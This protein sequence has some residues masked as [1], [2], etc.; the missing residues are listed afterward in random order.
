[1]ISVYRK[2]VSVTNVKFLKLQRLLVLALLS[3]TAA[4]A[5]ADGE[6]IDQSKDATAD[7]L[8]NINVARGEVEIRG[9]NKTEVQV[10]GTLDEKTEAFIFTTTS[11]V[12]E[13]KVKVKDRNSS[14]YSEYGSDLTIYVPEASSIEF[15]GVSTDV[16][17]RGLV[18]SV[19]LQV[20][21]G[22]LYLNGG[23]S[24]ITAQTVSGDVEL[25]DSTG[26]VRVGTVSGEVET[27]N[28]TGDARY[29]TVSGDI[30][31]EDG[32]TDLELESVSGDIEVKNRA[33]REVGGHSV[34]GDIDISGEPVNRSAIEFDSVSGSI[35][36]R[37]AGDVNARFDVETGSG[38][39]RN[40]ISDDKPRVSRFTQ[41]ETLKF[42][43]GDGEGQVILTTRSGDISISGR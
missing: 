41:E 32:G 3:G 28:T 12:T 16:D 8:V 26:R 7:G 43:L 27:Y 39:I 34:S 13:I 42:T 37:L 24:R 6:Y 36:V 30:I 21:S 35:R 23:T 10:K 22:D 11:D 33:M 38:S 14:W 15:N 29:S 9:W 18:G 5:M 40:R 2:A 31:V 4:M 25:H 1:M 19:D 20:V 17:A